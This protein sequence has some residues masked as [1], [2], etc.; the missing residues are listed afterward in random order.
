MIS[1]TRR[2]HLA[3]NTLSRY[4]ADHE[5]CKL[6]EHQWVLGIA[7]GQNA[8]NLYISLHATAPACRA[9]D[10]QLGARQRRWTLTIHRCT[11]RSSMTTRLLLFSQPNAT[12]SQGAPACVPTQETLSILA[13][14]VMGSP[15]SLGN[16]NASFTPARGI[17]EMGERPNGI[18]RHQP[19]TRR[20][21]SG[22]S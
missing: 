3:Q 20:Q 4:A 7:S 17:L 8:G 11:D 19:V 14:K 12:P 6:G 21:S 1:H 16:R 2:N 13:N 18:K 10:T 9:I 5:R 22:L 15:Q